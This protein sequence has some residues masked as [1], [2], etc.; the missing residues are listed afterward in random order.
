MP[1]FEYR[2][3]DCNKKFSYLIL[4]SGGTGAAKCP[5]CEGTDLVKVMSS[6]SVQQSENSR[7]AN[8]DPSKPRDNEFYKDNRNIGLW[9]K[10]RMKQLGVKPSTRIED[11]IE[12]ARSGKILDEA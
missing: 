3:R 7:L 8:L 1:I 6:F 12:K 10:K 9:A 2:C 5:V 11:V 4:K